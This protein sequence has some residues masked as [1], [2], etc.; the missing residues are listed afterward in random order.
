MLLKVLREGFARLQPAT[1]RAVAH[2]R[3]AS[4]PPEG[5][6]FTSE[7]GTSYSGLVLLDRNRVVA[8]IA[9]D[10]GPPLI[11]KAPHPE[12]LP[13]REHSPLAMPPSR[14]PPY[15]SQRSFDE[16]DDADERDWDEPPGYGRYK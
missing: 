10:N 7:N 12:R 16:Y 15:G 13:Q 3:E 1:Q 11:H 14:R 5:V 8:M 2:L 4:V 9:A 6:S